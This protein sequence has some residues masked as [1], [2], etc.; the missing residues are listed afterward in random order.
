VVLLA[1]YGAA[2]LG[3]RHDRGA[4][5]FDPL[6][7]HGRQVEVAIEI[8]RFADALPLALSLRKAYSNDPEVLYWLGEIYRGLDRTSDEIDAWREYARLSTTPEAVCPALPL[9]YARAG[10]ASSALQEFERCATRAP[11][12]PERLVDLAAEH[13][14]QGHA[15]RALAVYRQARALDPGDPRIPRRIADLS[16]R[17]PR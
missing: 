11:D 4:T 8:H 3:L 17:E 10:E 13:A 6:D 1:G 2:F 9:A 7:R 16:R 12:D 14:R 15:E 5:D